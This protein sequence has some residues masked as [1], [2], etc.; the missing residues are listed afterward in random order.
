MVLAATSVAQALR[1]KFPALVEIETE[2]YDNRVLVAGS[3]GL[4]GV[5]LRRCVAN[6]PILRESL[7]ILSFR[8]SSTGNPNRASGGKKSERLSGP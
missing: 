5:S 3:E 4:T 8:S 6:S 1:S 2:D 7:A